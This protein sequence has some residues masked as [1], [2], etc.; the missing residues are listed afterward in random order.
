MNP[1]TVALIALF[2]IVLMIALVGFL[3]GGTEG[4]LEKEINFN[5]IDADVRIETT[6]Y[7]DFFKQVKRVDSI[8]VHQASM[9]FQIKK[10]NRLSKAFAYSDIA[11][12]NIEFNGEIIVQNKAPMYFSQAHYDQIEEVDAGD[13]GITFG[14]NSTEHLILFES[15][16][17]LIEVLDR[18]A[19]IEKTHTESSG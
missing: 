9:T 2:I 3:K 19:Q 13:W 14:I 1:L 8:Y 6:R 12:F 17:A 5:T 11:Y 4:M 18:L 7:I 10:N 15:H 16:A